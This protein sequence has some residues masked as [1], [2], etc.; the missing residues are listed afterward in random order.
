M[1]KY[2]ISPDDIARPCDPVQHEKKHIPERSI[3]QC[4]KDAGQK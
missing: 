2:H 3:E 4:L 1:T